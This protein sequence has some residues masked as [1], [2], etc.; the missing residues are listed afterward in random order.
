MN[1]MNFKNNL[2]T[3]FV[4]RMKE[5][6]G[7]ES[8]IFFNSYDKEPVK[9]FHINTKR[10][11]L[12]E[13]NNISSELFKDKISY[14]ENGFYDFS[15]MKFGYN[16]LSH[17]GALY[18]QDPAAMMPASML[19]PYIKGNEKILDMCSAPGGK[20]SM[21]ACLLNDEDGYLVANEINPSRNNILCN[22]IERMG[23]K[24]VVVTKL[25]PKDLSINYP[26]YFDIV[27]VDAPCSGE[28]MFRKYPESINEWSLDN[29]KLCASRQKD[30]LKEAITCLNDGGYLL[31]STCTYAKEE[32]EEII[33]WILDNYNFNLIEPNENIMKMTS[34]SK[35]KEG[36]IF[37]PHIANGEGQFM[38]LLKKE[39][40]L[41]FNSYSDLGKFKSISKS[42][43][44]MLKSE[45]TNIDN[46]DYSKVYSFSDSYFYISNE[47]VKLPLKGITKAFINIGNVKN[48]RFNINHQ[49]FHCLGDLF[50]NY[51]DLKYNSEEISKYLHGEELSGIVASKGYGVIKVCGIPVG[52]FKASNDRLKNHYPKG[53]RNN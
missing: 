41:S 29:V 44:N 35:Y 20:A 31:Y 3:D 6:L 51:V 33:T 47:N 39:G 24:N 18:S 4:I 14:C 36:R 7:E 23:Y 45:I 28:G 38:C 52:G 48:K 1:E 9:A 53:L 26:S 49:L 17:A 5:Y 34:G 37:Y 13:L 42:E 10:L 46:L 8:E 27:V 43:I 21:L 15:N 11:A 22:N 40:N 25:D 50:N 2:P 16:P 19:R 12:N 32:D 30:I